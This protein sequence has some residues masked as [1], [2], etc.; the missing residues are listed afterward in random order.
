MIMTDFDITAAEQRYAEYATEF[1]SLA[2]SPEARRA[3]HLTHGLLDGL[4]ATKEQTDWICGLMV[5]AETAE[6][7]RGFQ[8]GYKAGAA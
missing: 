8:A 5:K 2:G 1:P 3:W 7:S 6:Y 4:G